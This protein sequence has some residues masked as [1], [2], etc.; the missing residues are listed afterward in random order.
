MWQREGVRECRGIGEKTVPHSLGARKLFAT[1]R[2]LLY[3]SP[4]TVDA[5]IIFY[6]YIAQYYNNIIIFVH[7]VI[8]GIMRWS[9]TATACPYLLRVFSATAARPD[10][11]LLLCRPIGGG[12]GFFRACDRITALQY[13]TLYVDDTI[14]IYT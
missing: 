1:C 7:N 4:T 13:E 12:F 11:A 2:I 5:C 8:N 14:A 6:H 10:R 9:C 3:R